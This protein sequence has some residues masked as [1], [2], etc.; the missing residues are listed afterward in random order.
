MR[1]NRCEII[2]ASEESRNLVTVLFLQHRTGDVGDASAALL[3]DRSRNVERECRTETK[4]EY[5]A[6]QSSSPSDVMRG[7]APREEARLSPI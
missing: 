6:L 2:V 1:W 7:G 5:E 4:T 3:R